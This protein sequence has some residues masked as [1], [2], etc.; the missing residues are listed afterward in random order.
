MGRRAL[1]E[2]SFQ[3]IGPVIWNSLPLSVR[4]SSS[5][6]SFKQKL[7]THLCSSAYLS[8]VLFFSFSFYQLLTSN[9]C[10]CVC[11]CVYVRA[12]VRMCVCVCASVRAYVRACARVCVCVCVYVCVCVCVC[13]CYSYYLTGDNGRLQHLRFCLLKCMLLW[14]LSYDRCTA[15]SLTLVRGQRFIRIVNYYYQLVA[16][17]EIYV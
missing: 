2:R 10:V 11:V 7:K 13:V 3:Y 5:L 6:S 9:A 17:I 16:P 15:Q 8:A 14:F 12:C 1:G 4:H